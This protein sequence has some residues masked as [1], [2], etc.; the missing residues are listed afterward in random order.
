MTTLGEAGFTWPSRKEW[1]ALRKRPP[2]SFMD[3]PTDDA[4]WDAELHRRAEIE[5]VFGP[6]PRGDPAAL[7]A[8]MTTAGWTKD[9]TPLLIE[10]F[11][12]VSKT[13]PWL[14]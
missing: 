3:R 2:L 11:V 8:A 1:T 12:A 5:R 14:R 4:A 7:E 10:D 13:P 6:V 9:N